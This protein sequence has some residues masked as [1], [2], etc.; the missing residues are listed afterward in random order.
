MGATL[1]A[2]DEAAS[3][4][5]S[6]GWCRPCARATSSPWWPRTNGRP[7]RRARAAARRSGRTGRACPSRR[8]S[9]STCAHT[10][11]RQGRGTQNAATRRRRCRRRE[12]PPATY[13]FAI[14]THG[15]I[16][17][18]LRGR[19]VQG[20]QAHLLDGLAG[21]AHPAQAARHD[22]RA[23]AEDVRCIYLE[24]SGCYG[25][26]GHEDAA[27]DAALIARAI[28]RPVRVQ[29]MRADEHGWDPK[30]PPTLHR[31]ARRASTRRATSWPGSPSSSS[32]NQS[33]APSARRRA[34]RGDRAGLPQAE[35]LRRATSSRTRA[36]PYAV[37]E[38][39]VN[40]SA[41][42]A[43]T[44][45]QAVWI[46]TPGAD[47]E[48]LRQRVL[49][50]RAGGGGGATRWSSACA[51]SKDERGRECCDGCDEAGA[52]GRTRPSPQAG[53]R[54]GDIARARR[55]LRAS[56]SWYRTYV[57]GGGRGGGEPRSGE[58]RVTRFCVAPRLR[59]DHQPGRRARTRSRQRHADRQPHAEGGADLGPL[60]VTSLDWASYPVMSFPEVPERRDRADRPA[61]RGAWGAG[62]PAAVCHPVGDRQRG[63]RRDRR[64]RCARC[65]SR[66]RGSRR[67]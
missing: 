59:P 38:H 57:G 6:R 27:A 64:A 49:P 7:S 63:V 3:R 8:S 46:R 42:A 62:E 60:V 16:G 25:R 39:P 65:R 32:R 5:A 11:G 53:R 18:V 30:G 45:V 66:R 23:D 61:G 35:Q 2:V 20:R 33:A 54:S 36:V 43:E 58:I 9:G 24:G 1:E 31:P 4:K 44:L 47:A 21:D 13:D 51:T 55:L 41:T 67:R 48:H 56:T 40:T 14:H 15:S 19:R 10:P 29:W 26:N 37:P 28:G 34:G 22:A 17:P 12:A 52:A 50:G